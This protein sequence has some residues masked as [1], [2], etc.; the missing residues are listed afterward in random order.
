MTRNCR[1]FVTSLALAGAPF[2]RRALG[3]LF[4]V[5]VLF[6]ALPARAGGDEFGGSFGQAG[7]NFGGSPYCSYRVDLS[8]VTQTIELANDR[9]GVVRST[10]S[11][12]HKETGLNG[13]PFP[14]SAPTSFQYTMTGQSV[15]G[16]SVSITY[17]SVVNANFPQGVAT[18]T[19]VIAGSMI[20]GTLAFNRTDQAAALL[21][22]SVISPIQ[23]A[24]LTPSGVRLVVFLPS[25]RQITSTVIDNI[26]GAAMSV[27]AWLL[28]QTGGKTFAIASSDVEFCHSQ[29]PASYYFDAPFYRVADDLAQCFGWIQR[30][31]EEAS[32]R[33]VWV[34]Y[35]PIRGAC[36]AALRIGASLKNIS[37]MGQGD[38]DG[39]AGKTAV[40][41][42]CGATLSYGLDRWIGGLGH[43]LGHAFGLPHPPGCDQGL[44][45]CD[46]AALMWLGYATFPNTYLR[47]DERVTLGSSP[48]FVGNGTR[49]EDRLF[50]WAE[51]AY[52]QYFNGRG[53]VMLNFDGYYYRWYPETRN[54]LAVKA[55]RV[56]IYGELSGYTFRDVGAL[57]D[58]LPALTAAGF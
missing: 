42:D 11:G 25:D 28:R 37:I 58:Y 12:T 29:R 21:R 44:Q 52:P 19:G 23:L 14:A 49:L 2:V 36:G 53:R 41:D 57:E 4:L 20:S 47:A 24:R 48:L 26:K 35:T 39:L 16:S 34:V 33:N 50:N 43:E 18:F 9:S 31:W 7:Q 54:Y 51:F 40:T 45:G 10:L 27:Q 13:C 17:A 56:V 6:A 8:N 46:G 15:V 32:G 30:P 3:P 1:H 38:I 55:G 22:W 5:L